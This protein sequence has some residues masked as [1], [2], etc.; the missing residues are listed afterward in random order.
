MTYRQPADVRTAS[1]IDTSALA[2]EV[3]QQEANAKTL[4]TSRERRRELREAR[5]RR[6]ADQR[7]ARIRTTRDHQG[8][9]LRIPH[10]SASKAKLW[11]ARTCVGFGAFVVVFGFFASPAAAKILAG[12]IMFVTGFA[13]WGLL[14][15]RKKQRP[16]H[17]YAA[18]N[19]FF[20]LYRDRADKPLAKGRLEHLEFDLRR[21]KAGLKKM[22][23]K[24]GSSRV[25]GEDLC[26]G[27]TPSDIKT[28]EVFARKF[29]ACVS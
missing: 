25:L 7:P 21:D 12:P 3:Q 4:G 13:L 2:L 29:G 8:V 15:L 16:V 14:G 26:D 20:V 1:L 19:G 9:L 10:L 28:L 27:L 17:V 11:L 24:H 22:I 5:V 6:K 18:N 23:I